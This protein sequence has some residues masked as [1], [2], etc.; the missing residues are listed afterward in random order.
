MNNEIDLDLLEAYRIGM[1][2][3]GPI[4]HFEAEQPA[5]IDDF[6]NS[7]V[8]PKKPSDWFAH[9]FPEEVQEFGP[10][11]LEKRIMCPDQFE[12][13]YPLSINEDSFAA[14]LGHQKCKR[15]IFYIPEQRFYR[16]NE[17]HDHFE[18][19]THE[20][21]K[22]MLSQQL[23][24]CAQ[25]MTSLTDIQPLL[26]KF[27]SDDVLEAVIKRAQSVLAKSADFFSEESGN[28]RSAS[29][30]PEEAARRFVDECLEEDNDSY[31]TIKECIE[32]YGEYSRAKNYPVI[33]RIGFTEIMNRF[34]QKR[35]NRSL[36]SDLLSLGA[37]HS[38]GFKG[39]R[40]KDHEV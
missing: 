18:L 25:E 32:R 21:L 7:T 33:P 30:V 1:G 38:R 11:I 4:L 10:P 36:R 8:A 29:L 37:E 12:R 17:T 5:P 6:R 13:I 26:T 14:I 22:L 31:V 3:P 34:V 40:W 2:L 16:F 9:H 39:V 23:I 19:A 35:F 20:D 24:K 15:T 27:R 28:R